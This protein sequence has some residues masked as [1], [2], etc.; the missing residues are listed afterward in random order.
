MLQDG[1]EQR[2]QVGA[3]HIE[4]QCRG[5]L[6]RGGE[7]HGKVELLLGGSHPIEQFEDLVHHLVG[8]LLGAVHLVDDQQG[9]QT[10]RQGLADDEAGLRHHALHRIHEQQYGVH[11]AEH[12]LHLAPEVGVPGRVHQVQAHALELYGRLLGVN[13]DAAFL[14]QIL[15]IH[16]AFE[17]F[18]VRGDCAGLTQQ[19]V[20]QRGLA[21]V[22]VSDDRQVSQIFAGGGH[23]RAG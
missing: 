6:L 19:P 21:M 9:T 20:E 14:F 23:G 15:A 22:D 17:D 3:R 8:A 4:I 18:A 11:Q 16:R 10:A 1:F 2:A 5:G 13:G 12:P 7:D